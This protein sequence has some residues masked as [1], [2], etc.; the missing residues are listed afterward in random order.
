MSNMTLLAQVARLA[1]YYV[2]PTQGGRVILQRETAPL[3]ARSDP[4]TTTYD[5]ACR[6]LAYRAGVD[7]I[8]CRQTE[9][10]DELL[11]LAMG[12]RG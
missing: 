12:P 4:Y 3:G 8:T 9:D 11:R 6:Q 10:A 7:S 2:T 1:G 5:E